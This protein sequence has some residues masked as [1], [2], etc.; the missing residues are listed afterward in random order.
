MTLRPPAAEVPAAA[1]FVLQGR[2]PLDSREAVA[3][4]VRRRDETAS[5]RTDLALSL[6]VA[7]PSRLDPEVVLRVLGAWVVHGAGHAWSGG[8]AAGSYT[9]P[10]G[11]DASAQMLRFFAG[12]RRVVA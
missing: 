4:A 12:C 9:D 2:A 5:A 8:D 10:Q 6:L 1:D 7:D 3:A 11:P